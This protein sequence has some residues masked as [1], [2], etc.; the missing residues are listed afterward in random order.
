MANEGR[1]EDTEVMTREE[2]EAAGRRANAGF[3]RVE[4]TET[5]DGGTG[6]IPTGPVIKKLSEAEI[7]RRVGD[8]NFDSAKDDGQTP[9]INS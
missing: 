5:E 3:A 1:P 6:E 2:R 8:G 7:R 9:S 4:R